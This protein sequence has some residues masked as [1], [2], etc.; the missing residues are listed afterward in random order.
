MIEKKKMNA[1]CVTFAFLNLRAIGLTNLSNFGGFL[2][3]LSP[4]NVAFV[5]ILFQLLL[6]LLPVFNTLNISSSAIPLPFGNGTA[7]LAALSFR[8]CLIALD[9]ALASLCVSRSS[10]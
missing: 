4:T 2:V 9:I 10:K 7:N 3:K 6:L 1:R 8:L 5:T